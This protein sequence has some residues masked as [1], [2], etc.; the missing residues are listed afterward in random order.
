MSIASLADILSG[1]GPANRTDLHADLDA[2]LDAADADGG[3]LDGSSYWDFV[4]RLAQGRGVE[5]DMHVGAAAAIASNGPLPEEP[6]EAWRVYQWAYLSALLTRISTIPG[7][8]M[9]A[10]FSITAWRA[11]AKN[12]LAGGGAGGE[13]MDL[14]ALGT[15][16]GTQKKAAERA[17]RRLLVGIVHFRAERDGKS[18]AKVRAD[19]LPKDLTKETWRGWMREVARAKMVHVRQVGA[20]ARAAARGEAD[21]SP[22]ECDAGE[23]EALVKQGWHPNG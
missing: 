16:R 12:A 18:V 13:Y 1:N 9:P 7:E 14:M 2:L 21:P 22:Y 6:A 20:D 8:I 15:Q 19:T 5:E 17:A 23:I 10:E 11:I 3:R 4:T